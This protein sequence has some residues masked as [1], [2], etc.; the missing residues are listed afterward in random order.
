ME[1]NSFEESKKT[2]LIVDDE[3][4]IVDILVYNLQKEGYNTLEANDGEEAINIAFDK[5]PDLILLDIM[6]PKVDGLTVCK[7]IR[8]SFNMP[9]IMISAKDEEIDKILGLELG[10]DDYITKPFSVRE[11]VARVKANLRKAEASV[12]VEEKKKEEN[13]VDKKDNI[14]VIGELSL[15]LDKFEVKVRDQVIDLTLREFEVLKY[16]ANQP[17]QVVTREALLEK[18][19]G[20]EYYG[21]IRT[22]DVTIR[23]IREKIENDTSSPKILITKRG[24]GYYL[25]SK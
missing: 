3:K 12:K 23:R 10:A 5:K 4:P 18:V 13:V 21:D 24:V 19:W 22:V 15:N 2:I 20:Y 16:L 8:N 6:L 17:G 1:E 14:I 25:S 9:I 7:K 11:L